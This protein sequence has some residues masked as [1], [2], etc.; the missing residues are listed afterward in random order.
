MVDC[1]VA[2][3]GAGPAGASAARSLLKSGISAVIIVERKRLPRHKPCSGL[4]IPKSIALIKEH[5]GTPPPEIFAQP[6]YFKAMRW[7]F[8]SGRMLATPIGTGA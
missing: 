3:V 2:V 4:L 8:S 7:H 6:D 1:E 5:F